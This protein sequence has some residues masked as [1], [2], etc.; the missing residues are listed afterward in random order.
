[1]AKQKYKIKITKAYYIA[2]EDKDGYEVASD[3]SF[4]DY[5]ES[6]KIA[7]KLLAEVEKREAKE[8]KMAAVLSD[9]LDSGWKI[10]F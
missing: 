1:M 4:L 2:I 9:M 7:E 3:W 10:Q 5:K 6:K 8:D